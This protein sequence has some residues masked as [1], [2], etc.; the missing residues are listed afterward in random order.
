MGDYLV[1]GVSS[2]QFN[3]VKNKRCSYSYDDRSAI[4]ESI[5]F[6]D[7]VIVEDTWEQKPADV[8]A[9]NIDVFVMGSDWR[10]KFDELLEGLC[11]VVYLPRTENISTTS[12]KI[13]IRKG[14]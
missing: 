9:L 12:V 4:V 7:E 13:D 3:R 6:V 5:R 14:H 10:G 11:E 2:D 8:A 1:V